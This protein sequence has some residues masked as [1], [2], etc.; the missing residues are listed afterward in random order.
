L[1]DATTSIKAVF[2]AHLVAGNEAVAK[3]QKRKIIDAFSDMENALKMLL[4]PDTVWIS[5]FRQCR[6]DGTVAQFMTL[7]RTRGLGEKRERELEI[8]FNQSS[9]KS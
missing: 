3:L 2:V 5:L 9:A 4:S 7:V 1:S 6:P 8:Q